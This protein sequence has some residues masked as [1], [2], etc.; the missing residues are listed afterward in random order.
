[1]FTFALKENGIFQSN[2]PQ[3]ESMG[4]FGSISKP[5]SLKL[6]V[7]FVESTDASTWGQDLSNSSERLAGV[8]AG[9]KAGQE[10]LL[11]ISKEKGM[12]AAIKETLNKDRILPPNDRS[13]IWKSGF[14]TGVNGIRFHIK[15]VYEKEGIKA[16][17]ARSQ[18][19]FFYQGSH[20][21]SSMKT[22]PMSS[23]KTGPMSRRKFAHLYST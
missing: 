16:A 10:Y 22:G 12:E 14:R 4:E 20:S 9:V 1:M 13:D 6:G 5:K 19:H 17:E 2:A 3:A 8:R 7:D 11:K 15:I 21:V 18:K 23:M